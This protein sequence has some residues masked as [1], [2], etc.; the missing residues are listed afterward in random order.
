MAPQNYITIA[1]RQ[2]TLNQFVDHHIE[3]HWKKHAEISR[4]VEEMERHGIISKSTSQWSSPVILVRKKS[5]EFRFAV[6]FCALNS[7]TEPIHFPVTH[8][9]D[10]VDSI[11]QAKASV[12]SVLDMYSGFW[13]IPLHEDTKS[14]TGFTTH[15]GNYVFNKL[16]F[17]LMNSPNA[18]AMVMSEVLRGI[19]WHFAQVYVDDILVYSANFDQ[20]LKHLQEIFDRLHKANLRLK[21]SKCHFVAKEVKYLGHK[22]TKEGIMVDEEKVASVLSYPRPKSPKDVRA[23]LGLCNYYR[24]F[25]KGFAEIARPLNKLLG[26]DVKFE[27]TDDCKHSFNQLKKALTE[28]PILVFP[29][30][31]KKFFLYV[32]AS[33]QAISYIL[34]QEDDKNREQVVSYGGPS[35]NKTER[36]W[37]ITDLEGLALV[38]GIRHF[39]VYLSDKPF[40]I[41]SDHQALK[42][43]KTSKATGRLGRWAV[44]LQGFQYEIIHKAGKIH[45]NADSLSRRVYD[46]VNKTPASNH[47]DPDALSLGPEVCTLGDREH[48]ETWEYKLHCEEVQMKDVMDITCQESNDTL[49]TMIHAIHADEALD[50]LQHVSEVC[51]ISIEDLRVKQTEDPDFKPMI[52]YLEDRRVPEDRNEANR[53][54]A[55]AQYYILENGILYHLYQPRSKGHKWTDVKKQLAVPKVMRD[56]VLKAY[57]D[58]LSGGQQVKVKK[59]HMRPFD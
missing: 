27:W 42:S 55:E 58:A 32:D 59:E 47:E 37:G 49:T 48:K 17:G 9:Q 36:N 4:Q 23:Y 38:E 31:S 41:Y 1:L 6:D 56:N 25:V 39:K 18:F 54:V 44:F 10:A 2:E 52:T 30:L 8:F 16:P 51:P 15:G 12:Y 28:G 50:P 45:S 53:I 26:K 13:Q 3:L 29:N 24:L 33:N 46:E 57:H 7:V 35:L 5:G 21:P 22:F 19:N 43:L 34:G 11:G 40:T 20:H 14:H